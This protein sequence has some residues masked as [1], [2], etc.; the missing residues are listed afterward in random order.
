MTT[1]TNIRK[2]FTLLELLVVIAIIAILASVV[3]VNYNQVRENGWSVRCKANLRSLYQASLNFSND[4]GGGYPSAG[5]FEYQDPL[6]QQWYEVKGWV[7]WVG[8]GTWP[9]ASPQAGSMHQQWWGND[10][11]S[12]IQLGTIWEYTSK[13]LSIFF[14]PKHRFL[15]RSVHGS[16]D[17]H[18]DVVRS[19]VMNSFFGCRVGAVFRWNDVNIQWFTNE[20][21]RTVMFADISNTGNYLGNNHPALCNGSFAGAN[22]NWPCSGDDSVL[23]AVAAPVLAGNPA[24]YVSTESIGY[25][26]HMSSE[27]RGHAV[28]LDGHIESVGLIHTPS[29]TWSNRT[30]DA[31]AGFY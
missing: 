19:Y 7:N 16:A 3:A 8:S 13:D 23:D 14:C 18:Y 29:G 5:P 10:A 9:N 30:H 25:V 22:G 21:S 26:H 20:A 17:P 28:F 6:N 1:Q 12:S 15:E 24:A 31:C 4:N 27:F 11:R 2:A